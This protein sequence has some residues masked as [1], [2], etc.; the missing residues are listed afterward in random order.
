MFEEIAHAQPK[1]EQEGEQVDE[2]GGSDG[3]PGSIPL[4]ANVAPHEAPFFVDGGPEDEF[5]DLGAFQPGEE[6]VAAFVAE[7]ADEL[8][9]RV[10]E[11]PEEVGFFHCILLILSDPSWEEKTKSPSHLAGSSSPIRREMGIGCFPIIE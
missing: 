4:P 7:G 11:D 8:V 6:G 3:Q 1:E 9:E 2:V 5:L 10:G